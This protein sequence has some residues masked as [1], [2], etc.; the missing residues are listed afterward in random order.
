MLT[1]DKL[2]I[3]KHKSYTNIH[4][5]IN[6]ILKSC[7]TILKASQPPSWLTR[8]GAGTSLIAIMIGTMPKVTSSAIYGANMAYIAELLPNFF[9]AI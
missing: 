5:K 4:K 7:K 2:K 3:I 1:E 6:I 9:L 8:E